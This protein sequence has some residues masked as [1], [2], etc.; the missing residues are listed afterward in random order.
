MELRGSSSFKYPRHPRP[1][2]VAVVNVHIAYHLLRP[3]SHRLALYRVAPSRKY[4]THISNEVDVF[5]RLGI[6]GD[7]YE[8]IA[9]PRVSAKTDD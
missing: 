9:P 6:L 5:V 4:D 7:R 3:Y 2:G 1:L 8:A